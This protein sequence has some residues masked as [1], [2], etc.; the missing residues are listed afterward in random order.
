MHELLVVAVE[1]WPG[2]LLLPDSSGNG[3]SPPML[4]LL[5]RT[6]QAIGG[7]RDS[8][9][10]TKFANSH[11]TSG[12]TGGSLQV[13]Q[14][15]PTLI[16]HLVVLVMQPKDTLKASQTQKKSSG[17]WWKSQRGL[18]WYYQVY[19]C[20]RMPHQCHD[21]LAGE[22]LK[23]RQACYAQR[24]DAASMTQP[25]PRQ[26]APIGGSANCEEGAGRG[27]RTRA[28]EVGRRGRGREG[29]EDT[30]AVEDA[31]EGEAGEEQ[32]E[33][34]GNDR[35][36]GVKAK[37][38]REREE[39]Q[40]EDEYERDVE[41]TEKGSNSWLYHVTS[42]IPNFVSSRSMLNS[43]RYWRIGRGDQNLPKTGN[44]FVRA[45]G[46]AICCNSYSLLCRLVHCHIAYMTWTYAKGD[47]A[48]GCGRAVSSGGTAGEG[49][50]GGAAGGHR[51]AL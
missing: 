37:E 10:V 20:I 34:S 23:L 7:K 16:R 50:G 24:A 6:V 38:G 25:P 44:F 12:G 30:S 27:R 45:F 32:E 41:R 51:E 31:G 18:P 1:M 47:R 39:R 33:R 21:D 14:K 49:S 9:S 3:G 22:V 40:K 13:S 17:K 11:K 2:P 48:H 43:S 29:K 5:S 15:L 26:C 4:N 42:Y 28:R 19:R 46:T 36:R 35:R 8:L